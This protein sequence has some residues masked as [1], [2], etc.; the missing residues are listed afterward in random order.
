MPDMASRLAWL[1]Q[2]IPEL[3]G[4]GIVYVLTVRDAERTAEWLRE[5]KIDA[6]AYHGD[7]E[8]RPHLEEMLQENRIKV[9]VAT[10]ALGMGYDKP[11]ISFVIHYQSPGSIISYYQQVGR[12]GRAVA[13]AYGVLISGGE[14]ADIMEYFRRNAFPDEEHVGEILSLL[15]LADGMSIPE[16]EA[17]LNL[18]RMHINKA[19]KFLS[20]E[21]PAP[22]IKDGSKW[23]RTPVKYEMN[24]ELIGRLTRQREAEWEE[25]QAV[26][27]QWNLPHVPPV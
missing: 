9:L 14:D 23:R 1:A 15:G 2:R 19:L 25:I 5:R 21:N 4:T 22:V 6:R 3:P 8:N 17:N 26:H 11:D 20:V 10:T 18:S 16:M 13:R 24:R 7:S 27:R 12:A